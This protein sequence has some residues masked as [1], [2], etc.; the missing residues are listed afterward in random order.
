LS[1]IADFV[2]MSSTADIFAKGVKRA[3]QNTI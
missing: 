2:T 3:S 1:P